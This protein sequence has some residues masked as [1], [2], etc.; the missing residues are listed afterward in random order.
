MNIDYEVNPKI[1]RGLDYYT[2]TVFEVEA[3]IKGFGSQNVLCGGG[4]YNNLVENIGG[5]SIPGVGFALGLERL[6]SALDAEEINLVNEEDVWYALSQVE[7]VWYGVEMLNEIVEFYT[8]AGGVGVSFVDRLS[9]FTYDEVNHCYVANDFDLDG[10]TT[11]DTVKIYIENGKLVKME[12]KVPVTTDSYGISEYVFSD[13][14][15]TTI[16]VPEWTPV[17]IGE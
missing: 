8:F 7:D 6:L 14:G 15:T 17:P 11:A 4:R 5:I 1:V 10:E 9:E 13:Y 12:V 3:T 2:H 16:D